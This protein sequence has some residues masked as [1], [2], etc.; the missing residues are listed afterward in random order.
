[1][2]SP[3]FHSGSGRRAF[4][5][6]E[7]LVVIAIIAILIGLL[8]PAV[9]K[10]REAAARMKCS[11][12]IKQL[13]LALHNYHDVVGVLPPGAANNITPF[14]SRASGNQWGASWMAYIMPYVELDNAFKRAQLATNRQYNDGNIRSGI[15][16]RAGSPQFSV[17]R[18]P[19]TSLQNTISASATA[20]GSMIA[21]Y[22]GIAGSYNTAGMPNSS[23]LRTTPYG[24]VSRDGVL[25]FNS[26]VALVAIT[27]GTSNTIMVGEV[28][29][30]L[31]HNGTAQRDN[32]PSRQ[33]GFA[34]GCAGNNN[35]ND[36][37]PN[38]SNGRVFN[39]T[40]LR[41]PINRYTRPGSPTISVDTCSNGLCQN[42]GNNS[43]LR[44]AHTGGVNVGMGDGSV[45]FLRE[46]IPTLLLFQ[47]ARR[48]DGSVQRDQ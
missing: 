48:G 16:D 24:L 27:D 11:N 8:L 43:V 37:V 29:A 28:G 12:N 32:R 34:M 44:S 22:V 5:L 38:N 23:T 1:M 9:Q 41:Y 18:C 10:V 26:K 25:H 45:R 42:A 30:P 21:D 3:V 33:H 39:T 13:G 31:Y 47:M 35:N 36:L 17:Y 20:P 14:G 6:I 46:S 40:T 2:S 15:G 19:S 4:T 7:L